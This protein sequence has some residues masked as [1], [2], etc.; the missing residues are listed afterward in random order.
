VT[1][2]WGTGRGLDIVSPMIVEWVVSKQDSSPAFSTPPSPL[3]SLYE[4]EGQQG[5]FEVQE[6]NLLMGPAASIK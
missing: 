5:E 2:V 4:R 3:P 6:N 1:N